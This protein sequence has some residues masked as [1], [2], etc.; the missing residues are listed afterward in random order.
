[1]ECVFFHYFVILGKK[2]SVVA[3]YSVTAICDDNWRIA[4]N[5]FERIVYKG[6]G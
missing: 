4:K 3:I 2:I 6:I 5:H 1:M